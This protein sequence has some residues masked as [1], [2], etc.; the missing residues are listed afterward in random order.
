[1]PL[2]ESDYSSHDSMWLYVIGW[3]VY[4]FMWSMI[5]GIAVWQISAQVDYN[6]SQ[7]SARFATR[8]MGQSVLH[9]NCWI[10]LWCFWRTC[11]CS[12]QKFLSTIKPARNW[13]PVDPIY[14]HCWVQWKKQYQVTGERD[15]TL[16]RRGTKDYTHSIKRGKHAAPPGTAYSVSPTS[17]DRTSSCYSIDGVGGLSRQQS[18]DQQ[19]QHQQQKNLHQ[20][21][22]NHTVPDQRRWTAAEP[23]NSGGS[24]I[25]YMWSETTSFHHVRCSYIIIR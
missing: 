19:S 17:L 5:I 18:S 6:F 3:I 4:L 2:T 8:S 1:M 24:S 13:G 11:F 15:F 21:H 16:R 23:K 10:I 12:L 14:R 20:Y 7:V 9:R 22:Y 25:N